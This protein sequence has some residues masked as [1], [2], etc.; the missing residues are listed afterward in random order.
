MNSQWLLLVRIF[1]YFLL[2]AT[3][4]TNMRL[5]LYI[6]FI[7]VL[8]KNRPTDFCKMCFYK[9][10]VKLPY[11]KILLIIKLVR[12]FWSDS[13]KISPISLRVFLTAVQYGTNRRFPSDQIFVSKLLPLKLMYL[14]TILVCQGNTLYVI[15]TTVHCTHCASN[16]YFLSLARDLIPTLHA[17]II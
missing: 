9:W 16:K 12:R 8:L 6:N 15:T 4:R 10:P 17:E 3:R 1:Y 11:F 14:L 13:E 7:F 2:M 5:S